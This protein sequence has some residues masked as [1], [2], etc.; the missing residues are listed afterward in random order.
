MNLTKDDVIAI[1]SAIIVVLA[2]IWLLRGL[3]YEL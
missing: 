2:I 3:K 1:L